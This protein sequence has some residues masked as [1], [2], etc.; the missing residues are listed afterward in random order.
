MQSAR[1][2]IFD[3]SVA[4]QK[5]YSAGL[6]TPETLI[7]TGKAR[8]GGRLLCLEPSIKSRRACS[9]ARAAELGVLQVDWDVFHSRSYRSKIDCVTPPLRPPVC[10]ICSPLVPLLVLTLFHP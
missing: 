3:M 7:P 8:P 6:L 9:E 1:G 4:V 10:Q 5:L 2:Q